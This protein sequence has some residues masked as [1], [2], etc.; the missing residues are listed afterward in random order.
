LRQFGFAPLWHG[1][2]KYFSNLRSWIIL[3]QEIGGDLFDQ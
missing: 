3:E 2:L 1:R